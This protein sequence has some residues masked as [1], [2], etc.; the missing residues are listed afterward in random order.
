MSKLSEST[1]VDAIH[2]ENS[3]GAFI[4]EEMKQ[5]LK[6]VFA[7]FENPVIVKVNLDDGEHSKEMEDFANEIMDLDERIKVEVVKKEADKGNH[8]PVMELWRNDGT[9]TGIRFHGVPGGHE[10][11]SFIVALYNASGSGQ[12][13]SDEL[14]K[15]ISAMDKEIHFK[16]AVSLSCTMCPEVVMATQKMASLN[17]NITAELY[18]LRWF[19]DLKEKYNIMSVPCLIINDEEVVFGKK[20]LEAIVELLEK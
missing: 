16:V 13:I 8:L 20:N 2:L 17:D 19:P 15:K 3:E 11:N 7:K 18:D 14:K 4:T 12:T 10:I 5:K 9:D 1:P 6:D